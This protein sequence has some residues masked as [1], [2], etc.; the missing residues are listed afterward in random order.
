MAE[1]REIWDLWAHENQGEYLVTLQ[2]GVKTLK[3]RKV[4]FRKVPRGQRRERR[5]TMGIDDDTRSN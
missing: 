5:S 3:T 1:A 4:E 2:L